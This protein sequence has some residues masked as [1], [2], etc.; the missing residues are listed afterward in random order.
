MPQGSWGVYG[1]KDLIQREED[2][3]MVPTTWRQYHIRPW[4]GLHLWSRDRSNQKCYLT[5]PVGCCWASMA[6][7]VAGFY[8][9]KYAWFVVTVFDPG[10]RSDVLL[11]KAK[12][13]T[14]VARLHGR[15]KIWQDMNQN[16]SRCSWK[17][18][19]ESNRS[20]RLPLSS[21]KKV[22][23]C[24]NPPLYQIFD[25]IAPAPSILPFSWCSASLNVSLR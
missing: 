15:D 9:S 25:S 5:K 22:E 1:S 3:H 11:S 19:D 6:L 17:N 18:Q 24:S 12:R 14:K 23:S 2:F 16:E 13:I 7:A 20:L 10:S 21:L 8:T 4:K